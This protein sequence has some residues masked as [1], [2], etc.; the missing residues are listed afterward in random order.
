MPIRRE[1]RC[2]YPIDWPQLSAVIRFRT[3]DAAG[4]NDAEAKAAIE[5]VYEQGLAGIAKH[6]R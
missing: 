2:F 5:G 4:M 1:P 6:F 3:F